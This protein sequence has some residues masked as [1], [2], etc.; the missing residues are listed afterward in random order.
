MQMVKGVI[1]L[2]ARACFGGIQTRSSLHR[3]TISTE[4]VNLKLAVAE[5]VSD[6]RSCSDAFDL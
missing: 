5:C 1:L 2:K 6:E 3:G 4:Y